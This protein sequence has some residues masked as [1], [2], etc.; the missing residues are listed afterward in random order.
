MRK[1]IVP[2]FLALLAIAPAGAA[3]AASTTPATTASQAALSIM[4]TVKAIDLTAHSLQL[5]DGSKYV[6][7]AGFALPANLKVGDKVTVHWKMN[8]SDHD[9]TAIDIG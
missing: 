5:A 7:P 9:V 4:G 3:F 8:G 1:Y 2:A 6:L